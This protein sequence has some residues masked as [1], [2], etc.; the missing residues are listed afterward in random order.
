MNLEQLK[1]NLFGEKYYS[2]TLISLL[3]ANPQTCNPCHVGTCRANKR[4]LHGVGAHY[5]QE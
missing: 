1:M 5:R 2:Y 3:Q 4:A